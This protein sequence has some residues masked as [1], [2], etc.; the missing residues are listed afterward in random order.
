MATKTELEQEVKTLTNRVTELE[1]EASTLD[2]WRKS[3]MKWETRANAM[4]ESLKITVDGFA[5][6][7][8]GQEP[9]TAQR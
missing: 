2:F 4:R 7:V 8:T 5:R 3:S 1:A 9:W 6:A